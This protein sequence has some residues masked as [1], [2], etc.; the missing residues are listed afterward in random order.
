M[1]GVALRV[2]SAPATAFEGE[3]EAVPLPLLVTVTVYS[4]GAGGAFSHSAFT[5]MSAVTVTGAFTGYSVP[6]ICHA[7]NCFPT[8]AI[9]SHSGR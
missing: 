3:A 9:N 5:V 2:I 7:L 6:S 4:A 1:S 8:G